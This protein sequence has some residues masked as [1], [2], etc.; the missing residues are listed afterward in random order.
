MS[1]LGID[2]IVVNAADVSCSDKKRKRKDDKVD[3]RKLSRELADGSLNAIYIP[4]IEMEQALTLT[5][6][7]HR[8]IQDQTMPSNT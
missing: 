6:Q 3:A 8:F 5:R 2:C 1:N 4:D 7:P